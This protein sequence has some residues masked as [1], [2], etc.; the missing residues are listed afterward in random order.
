MA[1]PKSGA[2][3]PLP[4]Q[5]P[6]AGQQAKPLSPARK[7]AVEQQVPTPK[8]RREGLTPNELNAMNDK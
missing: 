8:Q 4:G 6:D 1:E 7:Q 5:K 3:K 2:D